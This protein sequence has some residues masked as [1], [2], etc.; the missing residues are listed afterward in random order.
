MAPKTANLE[1]RCPPEKPRAFQG[2]FKTPNWEPRWPQKPKTWSQYGSRPPN[3][4]PGW[5]PRPTT[6]SLNNPKNLNLEPK[7]TQNFAIPCSSWRKRRSVYNI[8]HQAF[9]ARGECSNAQLY[10]ASD[11]IVIFY[12]T[13]PRIRCRSRV[14]LFLIFFYDLSLS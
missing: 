3:L 10:C 4:E 11:C 8:C 14:P 7:R 2:A 12:G 1:P 6:K 9:S 5:P 13:R